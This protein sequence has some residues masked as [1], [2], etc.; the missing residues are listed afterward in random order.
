MA[1]LITTQNVVPI[2]ATAKSGVS[3]TRGL[4]GTLYTDGTYDLAGASEV[5]QIVCDTPTASAGT[6]FL[7][8]A[9][10]G[11]VSVPFVASTTTAVADVLYTAASGKCT[12]VSTNATRIGIC[13]QAAAG[14]GVVGELI[15]D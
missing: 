12:N 1:E 5:G 4:R 10:N 2:T 3:F 14:D 11:S 13:K 8:A 9:L 6:I 15:P 7:A